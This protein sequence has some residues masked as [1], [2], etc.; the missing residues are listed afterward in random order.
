MAVVAEGDF[1]GLIAVVGVAVTVTAGRGFWDAG[2]TVRRFRCTDAKN[3][4]IPGFDAK[5]KLLFGLGDHA[6]IAISLNTAINRQQD[7]KCAK[8]G[9]DR[10]KQPSH[11][12]LRL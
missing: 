5:R 12:T 2:M 6:G 11:W 9:E 3:R 8:D 7:C 4:G 10:S 1:A